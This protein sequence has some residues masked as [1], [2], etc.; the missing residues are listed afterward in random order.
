MAT[1][2]SYTKY[3][4]IKDGKLGIGYLSEDNE[5]DTTLTAVDEAKEVKVHYRRK[6]EHFTSTLSAS[7]EFSSQFHEALIC[8]V[9]EKLYARKSALP[10]TR[11]WRAEWQDYLKAGRQHVN[12]SKDGTSY[13]I[14]QYD[15]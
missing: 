5:G 7:P 15:Y 11:Y 12:K 2:E 6:A 9:L 14:R 13:G 1:A 3:W 10:E 8:R 4:W